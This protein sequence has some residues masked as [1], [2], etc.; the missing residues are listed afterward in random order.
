MS[1]CAC[2]FDQ[3]LA[4]LKGALCMPEF[5]VPCG[6]SVV[7][8][9]SA[10]LSTAD[11]ASTKGSPVEI[12]A[13]TEFDA[14]WVNISFTGGGQASISWLVDLAIGSAT[15]QVIIP[16]LYAYN[17]NTGGSSAGYQFPLFIPKGS[18]LTA[19]AEASFGVSSDPL[20]MTVHLISGGPLSG[21]SSPLV[22]SYGAVASSVGTAI[23]PGATPNTDSAWVEI[24]AATERDHRW[25]AIAG[26]WGDG[27]LAAAASWT[28]QVGIG[29]AT[30]QVLIPDIRFSADSTSD[31]PFNAVQH[32]PVFIPAGSRLSVKVQSSSATDGDRDVNVKLYGC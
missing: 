26:K 17:R 30:E 9:H 16:N 7:R 29:A 13:A 14:N 19:I 3:F 10:I 21:G 8:V 4:A 24:A 28:V 12:V 1:E 32:F 2:R 11:A 22:S 23:D 5:P 18:R 27:A 25:L 6:S 20:R 15:E 31:F